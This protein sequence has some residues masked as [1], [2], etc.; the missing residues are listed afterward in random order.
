MK[1]FKILLSIIFTILAFASCEKEIQFRG[2]ITDPQIV[3]NS[4][5]TPDSVISAQVS[6]SRFFLNSETTFRNI[7]NA[8]ISLFVNDTFKERLNHTNNGIY[9]GTY[10]P[11]AGE[12]ITLKVLVPS[13][14]EVSCK[15][16]VESQTEIIKV[17]VTGSSIVENNG[18]S[19]AIFPNELTEETSNRNIKF[20]LTFSDEANKQNFYRLVV[21]TRTHYLN[22]YQ[23]DY[24]FS[25]DDIVSGNSNENSVGPPTSLSSNAYNVFSDELFNGKQYSLKFSIDENKY[26][27]GEEQTN[28]KKE[29]YINLQSISKG[30]YLYLKTR[31]ASNDSNGFF[32]EP[33][34]IYNNVE[35]GI[36]ILGSYTSSV[37]KIDL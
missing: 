23:D 33:I 17:D 9:K 19:S 18:T 13:K 25:F 3:V 12:T 26:Y 21:T 10:K 4:F 14:A 29:V 27:Y 34:Q 37:K 31:D 16:G 22:E 28:S 5:I 8:D 36:G 6:E 35:G 1:S 15:T 32:S 30:Y 2:E 11:I 20:T 24:N 7:E